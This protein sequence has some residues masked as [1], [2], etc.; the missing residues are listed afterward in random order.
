[1]AKFAKAKAFSTV[2]EIE[3][4]EM[5][6]EMEG[7]ERYNTQ[8][9]YSADAARHPNNQVT[10]SEKHIEHMRK[11]PEINPHQYIQNLKLITRIQ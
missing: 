11:F 6:T 2:S 4:L 5:L 3:V 1:M 9:R 10:F 7:D 8:S